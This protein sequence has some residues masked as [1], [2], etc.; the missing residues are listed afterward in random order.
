MGLVFLCP[1]AIIRIIYHNILA[2]VVWPTL[3]QRQWP[4]GEYSTLFF[5]EQ[6]L[7]ISVGATLSLIGINIG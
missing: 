4:I 5:L 2:D 7:L 3:D 6:Y 1:Q